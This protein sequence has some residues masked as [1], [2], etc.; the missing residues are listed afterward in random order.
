MK[1]HKDKNKKAR[2]VLVH[3]N[4]KKKMQKKKSFLL[5]EYFNS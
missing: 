1:V 5:K 4:K 3:E 2:K